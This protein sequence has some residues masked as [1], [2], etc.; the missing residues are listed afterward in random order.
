MEYINKIMNKINELYKLI[1]SI[2]ISAANKRNLT[3]VI[4]LSIE[5]MKIIKMKG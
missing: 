1:K 4:H 5:L 3:L 2:L